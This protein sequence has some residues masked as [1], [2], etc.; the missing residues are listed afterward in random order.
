VRLADLKPERVLPS[1]HY[2]VW[3]FDT[4]ID[5]GTSTEIPIE[6]PREEKAAVL[7]RMLPLLASIDPREREDGDPLRDVLA[8]H[9][10]L[11]LG[12]TREYAEWVWGLRE[13]P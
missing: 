5:E 8:D 10:I 12:V 2:K 9:A 11:R 7:E 6:A 1:L 3:L 13:K 4:M